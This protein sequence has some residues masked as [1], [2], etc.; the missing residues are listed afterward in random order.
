MLLLSDASVVS[1]L[2][3]A[4][5]VVS[6]AASSSADARAGVSGAAGNA[7][8]SADARAGVS[9]AAGNASI[10]LSDVCVVLM[11]SSVK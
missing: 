2:S 6:L 1:V 4:A 10:V 5:A 3:V 9:G 11:S 8:S 7:S